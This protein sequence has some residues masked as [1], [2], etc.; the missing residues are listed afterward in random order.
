[1]AHFEYPYLIV[2]HPSRIFRVGR[3]AN[4]FIKHIFFVW[5]L[6]KKNHKNSL[7]IEEKSLRAIKT[8]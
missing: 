1:M 6:L 3:W 8:A 7:K 5:K 2:L 4:F